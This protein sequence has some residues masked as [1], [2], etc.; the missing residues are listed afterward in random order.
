MENCKDCPYVKA[1]DDRVDKLENNVCTIQKT[2]NVATTENEKTKIYYEKI[3]ES[4]NSLKEM[5]T[6]QMFSFENRLKKVEQAIV[7][8]AFEDKRENVFTKLNDA[9]WSTKILV[10]VLGSLA[11]LRLMGIDLS[12]FLQ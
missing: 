5:F 11:G 7:E 3:I 10:Y 9:P 6:N 1:L 12:V 2:L 8:K 4:I